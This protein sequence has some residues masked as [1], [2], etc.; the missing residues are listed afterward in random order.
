MRVTDDL[1]CSLVEYAIDSL[2]LASDARKVQVVTVLDERAGQ[3]IGDPHRLGQV[4]WNLLSNAIKFTPRGGHIHV[5]V[6]RVD[7]SIRISVADTGQGIAPEFLPHVFERFKQEDGKITRTHG[8]LG[9]GLAISRHIVELHGGQ[10]S[11]SSKGEGLGSTFTVSLPVAPLA[12]EVPGTASRLVG[13]VGNLGFQN[14]PELLDLKI[15]V[16]D[17]EPDARELV[18]AV[19]E[20]V[21]AK[22]RTAGSVVEALAAVQQ[23]LP[24]LLL[25]DIGMPGEDGYALIR[26]FRALPGAA[27]IPAAALTAYARAEDRRKA[28]DAGFMMHIPKPVEPAELLSVVANLTRFAARNAG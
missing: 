5:R 18:A 13:S 2:R 11:A 16:V 15:L 7:S 27:S 12:Q 24:E 21:G 9:L 19:L 17:D 10:I 6:E 8:G 4:M 25:S 1:P 14:R 28:L 22:V 26:K 20:Q 23:E 3:I